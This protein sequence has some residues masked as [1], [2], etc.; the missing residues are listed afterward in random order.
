MWEEKIY[1]QNMHLSPLGGIK[2]ACFLHNGVGV[3]TSK[4]TLPHFTLV[5]VTRGSGRYIDEKGID[6]S[7]EAG[8]AIIVFPGRQHWYGPEQGKTWDEFYLVF[9]G[10]VFDMWRSTGCFDRDHPVLPLKPMDFWRDRILQVIGQRPAR[11]EAELLAEAIKLQEL[12][13]DMQQAG[14]DGMADEIEWL[15]GAKQAIANSMDIRKAAQSCGLSYESFRKRFRKLA[16]HSPGR[17]RTSLLMSQACEMLS[18]PGVRLRDISDE[19]GFCDEYH[20]SRQFRKSVGWSPS[21]YRAR[22]KLDDTG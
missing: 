2:I 7:V 13:A 4:R 21:E 19:L 9:E 6:V 12:L 15:E 3:L 1:K 20:F 16:G 5:Y 18:K 17:H 22:I 10:P 11:T 14:H 8:D